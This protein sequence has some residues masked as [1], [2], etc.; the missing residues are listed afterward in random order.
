[1]A[2]LASVRPRAA[3]R[4]TVIKLMEGARHAAAIARSWS[5]ERVDDV[6]RAIGWHAFRM[7]TARRLSRLAVQETGLGTVEDTYARHRLRILATMRDLDHVATVGVVENCPARGIRKIA[8]P[9][10]VIAA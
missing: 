3:D 7:E 1:M 9:V 2:T 6:V 8:K 10:G 4:S 5:Q